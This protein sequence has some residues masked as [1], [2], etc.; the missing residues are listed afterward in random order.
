MTKTKET[1]TNSDRNIHIAITALLITILLTF[2]GFIYDHGRLS[3]KVDTNSTTV[4]KTA[5]EIGVISD[6]TWE[7]KVTVGKILTILQRAEKEHDTNTACVSVDY[8]KGD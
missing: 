4:E 5:V 7:T 6:R 2:G 1:K 3:E 8:F